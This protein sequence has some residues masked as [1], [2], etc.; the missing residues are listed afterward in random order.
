MSRMPRLISDVRRRRLIGGVA[1][2]VAAGAALLVGDLAFCRFRD[3][4][5]AG[6][7]E[8]LANAEARL[9]RIDEISSAAFSQFR[10]DWTNLV[11]GSSARLQV[12]VRILTEVEALALTR[13]R[14]CQDEVAR[15]TNECGIAVRQFADGGNALAGLID[16]WR[17]I[18]PQV[19]AAAGNSAGHDVESVFSEL[20]SFRD[21][22]SGKTNSLIRLF[23]KR[24]DWRMASSRL[25]DAWEKMCATDEWQRRSL[26]LA[27]CRGLTNELH[28]IVRCCSDADEHLARIVNEL[29]GIPFDDTRSIAAV[30]TIL[31]AKL[32]ECYKFCDE[33][34]KAF[35]EQ[36]ES[37]AKCEADFVAIVEKGSAELGELRRQHGSYINAEAWNEFLELEKESSR[38]KVSSGMRLGKVLLSVTN[39]MARL[40]AIRTEVIVVTNELAQIE[41]GQDKVTEE[42]CQRGMSLAREMVLVNLR[43]GVK[44]A[45]EALQETAGSVDAGMKR[46]AAILG[47]IK[48]SLP[49][50]SQLAVEIATE[51][52][53]LAAESRKINEELESVLKALGECRSEDEKIMNSLNA[54]CY[55]VVEALRV[56]GASC[57]EQVVCTN[58]VSAE[59][60]IQINE[61]IKRAL[62]LLREKMTSLKEETNKRLA[63]ASLYRVGYRRD[64]LLLQNDVVTGARKAEFAVDVERAGSHRIAIRI[65]KRRGNYLFRSSGRHDVKIQGTLSDGCGGLGSGEKS[66][67]DSTANWRQFELVV[68]ESKCTE[69][70]NSFNLKLEF[71]SEGHGVE[72]G[73]W[74]LDL[75]EFEVW[76]DGK[77]EENVYRLVRL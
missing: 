70:K 22:L 55:K 38:L 62:D 50:W 21:S 74:R 26:L 3:N 53:S 58:G 63:D 32:D 54:A 6:A 47:R 25:D 49:N 16:R 8:K 24:A 36:Q 41:S 42:I 12:P 18:V 48:D 67:T 44:S 23:Q 30:R 77:K 29:A 2:A 5:R 59:R 61:K 27:E 60:S 68:L 57:A 17:Q 1:L 65:E 45:C 43:E 69:G 14:N 66:V 56:A 72:T 39:E 13:D 40:L 4:L 34:E 71:H 35:E 10:V 46:F 33:A 19:E 64:P 7:L 9:A 28:G 31:A 15:L 20:L 75:L 11:A 52:K 51:R 37:F 73:E 76:I